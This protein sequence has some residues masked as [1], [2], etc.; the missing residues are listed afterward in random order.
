MSIID[1][2]RDEQ[3]SGKVLTKY[4][5]DDGNIGLIVEDISGKRYSVDFKTDNIKPCFD[6][7]YGIIDE[8]F[9]KKGNYLDKLVQSGDHVELT[10]S[11][12][13]SPFR[14]AYC[15]HSVSSRP[16]SQRR[17]DQPRLS[18]APN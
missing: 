14:T 12:S 13:K 4:R 1:L 3:I 11:Y 7:L 9:K 2:F 18:Y 5:H 8:P 10:V 16:L 6:N 15:L 17:Y